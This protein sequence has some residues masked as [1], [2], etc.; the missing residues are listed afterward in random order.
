MTETDVASCAVPG[1]AAVE[2][3]MALYVPPPMLSGPS[4]SKEMHLRVRIDM[5]DLTRAPQRAAC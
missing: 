1:G 4:N 5:V 2:D 3:G